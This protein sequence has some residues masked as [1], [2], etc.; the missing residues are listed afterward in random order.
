MIRI[1][2]SIVIDERELIERFIRSSGP[3]GQNVNKLATA[4]ELRFD[5]AR[6]PAL[7]PVTLARLRKLAGRRLTDNGILVIKSQSFR[8]Q[9]RNRLEALS[10]LIDLLRRAAS[11]PA[12]RRSTHPTIASIERRRR[13][14]AH[15]AKLKKLRQ[16]RI[17]ED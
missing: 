3:G 5:A 12:P 13:A 1:T 9:E 6:S 16:P 10:R 17:E 11:V 15:R 8:T 14:K 2:P 7:D 4:V